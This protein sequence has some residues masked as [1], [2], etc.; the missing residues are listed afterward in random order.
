[1][2][3]TSMVSKLFLDSY[4]WDGSSETCIILPLYRVQVRWYL[5]LSN[6]THFKDTMFHYESIKVKISLSKTP[7]IIATVIY[8]FMKRYF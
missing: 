5:N 2:L 7:K 3:D 1:M 8:V 4:L 6:N